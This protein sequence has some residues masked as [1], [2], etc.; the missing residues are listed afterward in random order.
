[1]NEGGLMS[2]KSHRK[3]CTDTK[4]NPV[5]GLCEQYLSPEMMGELVARKIATQNGL[6]CA[7]CAHILEFPS[8]ACFLFGNWEWTSRHT[9]G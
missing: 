6:P 1:M 2:H 8:C 4:P 9:E 3:K 5:N 7:D